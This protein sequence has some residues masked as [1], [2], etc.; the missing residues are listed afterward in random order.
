MPPELTQ[1]QQATNYQTM[2]HI[3]TVQ[4]L[5]H[6]V[7]VSLMSRALDHD[8]SKLV[9]PEVEA[10]TEVTPL[11]AVTEYGSPEYVAAKQKLGEA[12]AHHYAA[13][14]HHP[15][16]FE[17]GVND[18]TLVD[19][20]EMLCDWLASTARNKNGDIHKS[21]QINAARFGIGPQLLKIL[22]NTVN[23]TF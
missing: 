2:Q 16:H 7:V 3:A 17:N 11:L 14:R 5:L 8:L 10:F 15:E 18:M 20:L 23:R 4:R 21:L 6:T 19:L 12:L 1:E 9:P 13:N 22:E